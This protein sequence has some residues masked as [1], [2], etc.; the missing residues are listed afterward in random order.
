MGRARAFLCARKESGQARVASAQPGLGGQAR[1]FCGVSLAPGSPL[2]APIQ[3]HCSCSAAMFG[4]SALCC[5]NMMHDWCSSRCSYGTQGG[6]MSSLVVGMQRSGFALKGL[7]P[8]RFIVAFAG[9]RW[10]ERGRC[11]HWHSSTAGGRCWASLGLESSARPDVPNAHCSALPPLRAAMALC[12]H[13]PLPRAAVP[14]R[15]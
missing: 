8:L 3:A 12:P 9:I 2:A 11:R 15:S 1:V 5:G 6:A 10:V 7:P 13:L 14:L 4:G